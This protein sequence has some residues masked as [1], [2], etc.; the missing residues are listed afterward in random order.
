[1]TLYKQC[2]LSKP[3]GRGRRWYT[4]WIP[5][6][7]AVIGKVMKLEINDQWDDGWHVDAIGSEE[8]TEEKAEM[9][10]DIAHKAIKRIE[11]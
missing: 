11:G 7:L 9:L 6:Q 8:I 2:L 5:S 4:A 10:A 1:M 3:E